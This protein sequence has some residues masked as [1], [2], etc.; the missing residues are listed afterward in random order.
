MR[1][2]RPRKIQE[3]GDGSPA[4]LWYHPRQRG[5]SPIAALFRPCLHTALFALLLCAFLPTSHAAREPA[6]PPTYAHWLHQEVNYLITDDERQLFL[7]LHTNQERDRFIE[8]FWRA[9]NPDPNAPENATRVTHYQRLAYANTH[10]AYGGAEDGWRSDRGMAYITLGAPQQIEAHKESPELRPLEIWFYQNLSSALPPHFYLVFYKQSPAEDYEL[11]SPYGDR[12]QKLINSTNAIND[13]RTA[14]KLIERDLNEE[15]AHVALSLIPGEPVDLAHPMPSLQSDVLLNNIRN[16]RNL[17]Q[18]REL[19]AAGRQAQEAVS[20]R[21]LLGEDFS[22]LS[23]LATRDPGQHSS[24]HYLLRLLHPDDFALV[25]QPTGRYYYSLQ[26]ET[27]LTTPDGKPLS[28]RTQPLSGYLSRD[29]STRIAGKCFGVEGRL[30]ATPG[31]YQLHLTLTNLTTHQ[32][33]R[34]D[35]TIAVPGPQDR[36]GISRLFFANAQPPQTA[37]GPSRPFSFSGVRLHPIGSDHLTLTQG[38]PL[39]AIFQIWATPGDPATLHGQQLQ[40]HYLIGRLDSPQRLEEDQQ[41]DRGSFTPDGNL[42]LGK[43]LRTDTLVP[44]VYRLVVKVSDPG[45]QATAYQSLSFEVRDPAHPV[46]TLWTLD[47]PQP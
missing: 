4:L 45:S 18:I 15:A 26:L 42:L 40:V 24:I 14:I 36:L 35:R 46:P 37:P 19:V 7:K 6:L 21:I 27:T 39:R 47:A 29:A 34:Q 11:Y 2:P 41:V 20:H 23:V 12:P 30:P 17:P 32:A 38:Q 16:Y 13:D 8:T 9:R 25:E 22:D 28:T 33:F 1:W 43:D 3:S 44:G 31:L 10:F 5:S